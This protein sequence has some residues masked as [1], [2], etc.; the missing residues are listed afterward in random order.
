MN[1]FLT[2]LL[3]NPK[4]PVAIQMHAFTPWHIAYLIVVAAFPFACAYFL[5]RSTRER[6][7]SFVRAMA[8][9]T[10]V[11]YIGDFFLQPF[12]NDGEM[13]IDKLPFHICTLLC[14]VMMLCEYGRKFKW[15]YSAAA[16]LAIATPFMYMAYPN[17]AFGDTYTPWSYLVLQPFAYHGCVYAWGML[18]LLFGKVECNGRTVLKVLG[19]L[20]FVTGW[21]SLGNYLYDYNWFFLNKGLDLGFI[22]FEKPLVYLVMNGGVFAMVMI[23]FGIYKLATRKRTK[24]AVSEA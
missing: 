14:P 3:S 16:L 24:D 10:L 8:I 17:T 5:R 23:V 20:V 6:K 11:L 12:W 13:V 2:N 7:E 9:A 1:E 18:A 21:A 15:L 4:E 22:E 19:F